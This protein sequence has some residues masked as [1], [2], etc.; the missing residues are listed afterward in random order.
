MC[1][2]LLLE[3]CTIGIC[4]LKEFSFTQLKNDK[5]TRIFFTALWCSPCMN[6]YKKIIED[7]KIDTVHN[8]IVVFDASG[9][10][11]EKLRRMEPNLYD[12]AKSF[13]LPYKHYQT[14]KKIIFNAPTK[15]L[16]K[17]IKEVQGLYQA[18]MD[19][20][21]FWYGDIILV[22]VSNKVSYSQVAL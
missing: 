15:A 9:F 22:S 3:F 5:P 21:D 10:T 13:L 20:K 12:T 7:F 1:S 2:I 6:K 4:Q 8:N 11:I 18:T 19:F 17:F 14:S 16:K